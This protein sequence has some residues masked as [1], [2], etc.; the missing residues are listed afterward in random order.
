MQRSRFGY[1][2][3]AIKAGERAA[4]SLGVPV[5]QTKLKAL[6]LSAAFTS[7]AGSLYAIKTGFIDPESG[8]GIL[9]SV[10]MVIIA[11]LGG[12]GTL[13][14]PLVGALILVPLQT[15][16]N[17]WFGGGGSGPHLHPLWRHHRAD[18]ALRAGRAATSCGIASRRSSG[19][20][21][22][23]LE[24]QR[25]LEGVRQLP[26][27]AQARILSV[28]EGEIIGLIGPN[29]AGK[30]TFF[31]CLAGDTL[32]TSGRISVRRRRRDARLARGSMRAPASAAP[33][34]CRRRSRT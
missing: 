16:T 8:F 21:A 12:A 1:Y 19:E 29:G 27:G 9:V 31:N 7:V 6:M 17:T 14:G 15:A 34:R 3:R 25:R 10:Q 33:F 24:A 11:A 26:C 28:A 4:R 13:F 32:P 2:L 22:M 20:R 23:L 5:R 18:R 30:S